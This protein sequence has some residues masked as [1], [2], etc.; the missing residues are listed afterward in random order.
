[1]KAWLSVSASALFICTLPSTML[2]D[3]LANSF[4][5]QLFKPY[6]SK[7]VRGEGDKD[8]DDLGGT[9]LMQVTLVTGEMRRTL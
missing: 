5:K 7:A 1:M 6:V 9:G 4:N 8:A 2:L 3:P